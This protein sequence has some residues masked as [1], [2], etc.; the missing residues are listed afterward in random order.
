MTPDIGLSPV[1]VT[2]PKC[3]QKFEEQL[4]RFEAKDTVHCPACQHGI[5][6]ELQNPEK[7]REARALADPKRIGD[8]LRRAWQKGFKV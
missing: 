6:L 5:R 2:C 3:G 8:E 1:P 7:L 4:R